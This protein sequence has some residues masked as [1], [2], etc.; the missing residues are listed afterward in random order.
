MLK[1]FFFFTEIGPNLSS[2]VTEVVD[3]F[4]EFLSETDENFIFEE[5]TTAE[6]FSLQSKLCQ[7]KATGLDNISAKLLRQCPDLLS[8]SLTVIFN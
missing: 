6:V 1:S 2:H 8:E 7:T 3:S 4:E 5:T